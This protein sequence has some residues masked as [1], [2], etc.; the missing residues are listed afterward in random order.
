[1]LCCIW[2]FVYFCKNFAVSQFHSLQI[3]SVQK[4]T[5]SSITLTF[6]IP[7][8]L[9]DIFHF[10]A[11]QYIT[12]R[13]LHDGEELRRAYSICSPPSESNSLSVGIK[14]VEDGIFSVFANTAL[15]AGDTLEV[16]PPEGRFIYSPGDPARNIMAIAAGSGITPIMSIAKT[17]LDTN[18]ENRLVLL[19][20]NQSREETMFYESLNRLKEDYPDQF[21]LQYS[22]TRQ[23]EAGALFGRIDTAKVNYMV[24]NKFGH[25]DFD[26]YYICGP[27]PMIN[28]VKE[29]LKANK[30]PDEQILFELFTETEAIA[31]LPANL[32]DSETMI[33][34]ILDDEEHSLKMARKEL[35]LDAVLKAKIDAPYSCQGG[36]CST[37]IA[38]IKE[39][40]AVM[41]KNQI[42]TD[43]EIAEGFILTCQSHPTSPILVIDYDDV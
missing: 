1:M 41:E 35:V 8:T 34:V 2:Q 15:K 25:L 31:E 13:H 12:I 30:V 14:K 9:R 24:K 26:R 37:C 22:L 42:L 27:E 40:S 17:V 32:N 23:S 4:N 18:P 38:R 11:G 10:K 36:V 39:G 28:T 7:E 16:M 20:G 19:Y 6:A 29:C 43:G 33:K 3:T 5:P 21:F